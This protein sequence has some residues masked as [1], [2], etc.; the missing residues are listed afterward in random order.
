MNTTEIEPLEKI[1]I[2]FLKSSGLNLFLRGMVLA[3]SGL[4]MGQL[5]CQIISFLDIVPQKVLK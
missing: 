2:A 1:Q 5:R 3:G 4:R